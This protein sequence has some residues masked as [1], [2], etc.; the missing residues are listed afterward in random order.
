[1]YNTWYLKTYDEIFKMADWSNFSAHV[2]RKIVCIYAW[3]PQTIMGLKAAGGKKL[4]E[5]ISCDDVNQVVAAL[6][7]S[8]EVTRSEDFLSYQAVFDE[9]IELYSGLVSVLRPTATSK[10]LHF[11]HPKLFPMW[12]NGIRKKMHLKN[13]PDDYAKLIGIYFEQYSN[14]GLRNSIEVE[15]PGNFIRAFDIYLMKERK[16]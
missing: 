7:P 12:D 15:Y 14:D 16:P 5:I 1:M 2:P 11:S 8:F 10:Y 3:M 6:E 13:S 4:W 9:I